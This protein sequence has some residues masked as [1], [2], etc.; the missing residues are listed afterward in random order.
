MNTVDIYTWVPCDDQEQAAK[1]ILEE[2]RSKIAKTF[3]VTLTGNRLTL[4]WRNSLNEDL[5]QVHMIISDVTGPSIP[6]EVASQ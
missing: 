5:N 4:R 2:M 6:D 3:G 1:E